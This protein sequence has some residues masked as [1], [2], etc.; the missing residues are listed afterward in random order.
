MDE[1]QIKI[2]SPVQKKSK[3]SAVKRSSGSNGTI[4]I[5]S[6]SAS[7]KQAIKYKAVM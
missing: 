1:M 4:T 2:L 3:L 7:I 6:F 5:L